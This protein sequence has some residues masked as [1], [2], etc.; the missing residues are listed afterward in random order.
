[1]DNINFN[2]VEETKY[3]EKGYKT[4]LEKEPSFIKNQGLVADMLDVGIGE[5]SRRYTRLTVSAICLTRSMSQ[6]NTSYTLYLK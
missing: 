4:V 1:M 5:A 6:L 2:S 3:S